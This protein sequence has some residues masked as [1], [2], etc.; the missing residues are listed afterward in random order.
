MNFSDICPFTKIE[1]ATI[2]IYLKCYYVLTKLCL[3]M[4]NLE[5]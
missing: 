3:Y 4:L 1:E 2:E 5:S